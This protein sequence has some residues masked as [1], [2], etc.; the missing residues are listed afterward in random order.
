MLEKEALPAHVD[1]VDGAAE[2]MNLEEDLRS[3]KEEHDLERENLSLAEQL[4][5]FPLGM[6][7]GGLIEI[8][9][10]SGSDSESSSD[11]SDEE[12]GARSREPE[13]YVERV[14]NGQ[15]YVRNTKSGLVHSAKTSE[16][17]QNVESRLQDI[18]L[19]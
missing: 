19:C 10:S 12:S 9:S 4:S 6:V 16:R 3:V 14:P 5:L 1:E 17:S 13:S 8:E 18:L 2:I 15:T 11:T 7:N